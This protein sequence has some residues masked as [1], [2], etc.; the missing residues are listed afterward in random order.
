MALTQQELVDTVGKYLETVVKNESLAAVRDA[1]N[2]EIGWELVE[3]FEENVRSLNEDGEQE[4][5]DLAQLLNI[6]H[7]VRQLAGALLQVAP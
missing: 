2:A 3:T 5:T 4:A 1:D 7:A 6:A